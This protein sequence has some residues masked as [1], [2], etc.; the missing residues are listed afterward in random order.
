MTPNLDGLPFVLLYRALSSL[1]ISSKFKCFFPRPL[2]PHFLRLPSSESNFSG[3]AQKPIGPP[4]VKVWVTPSLKILPFQP[5]GFGGAES[6]YT[7]SG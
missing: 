3:F 7:L 6:A 1:S 5:R 2:L 4:D